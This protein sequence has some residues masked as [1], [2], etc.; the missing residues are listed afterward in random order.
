MS[1]V[2]PDKENQA[3]SLLII[4]MGRNNPNKTQ[5]ALW[6]LVK[7]LDLGDPEC[8]FNVPFDNRGTPPKKFEGNDCI[9]IPI[10]FGYKGQI[11]HRFTARSSRS[12][13]SGAGG[14][15]GSISGTG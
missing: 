13:L 10:R 14:V 9:A 11:G 12:S 2:Y 8:W 15:G 1:Y 4:A 5:G 7:V 3:I 6:E